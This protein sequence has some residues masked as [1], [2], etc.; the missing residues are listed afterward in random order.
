[1]RILSINIK[2]H[3]G[4]GTIYEE[5]VKKVLSDN[6]S[7]IE[8]ENIIPLRIGKRNVS[9]YLL[10]PLILWRLF[11]ISRRR[12]C[13]LTIRDFDS[14]LFLNQK[15]T[16]NIILFFHIDTSFLSFPFKIVYSFLQK[17]IFFN[18]KKADALVTISKYWQNYFQ[19]KGY[20]NI[21]LIYNAFNLGNYN[22][23]SKEVED[24]KKQHNLIGKPIIYIGDCQKAKGVKESYDTLKDL[25]VFL[26]TS[27]GDPR[28]KVP[29]KY[30]QLEHKDF[31]KLLK[32]SSIVITMSLFKEGWCRTAHE[33][34][35]LKT[36]VIGSGLGGMRELL[37]EGK[38]IICEDFDSLKAKVKYLL[39]HPE[40]RE[41]MGED[42]YNFAKNFT[43]ERFKNDWL[44]LIN[45]LI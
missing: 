5:M 9:K 37:E 14:S 36:P 25:D 23:T 41:K 17:L 43:L 3:S 38:Q 30:L 12:D 11:K 18:F 31:L 7:E 35:L 19:K 32:A 20:K 4:G 45:K 34:M 39:N 10:A 33:A 28:F 16:K 15:P 13:S 2:R 29:A 27:G 6:Y 21:F 24:F 26:V 44:D 40:I 1:M 42:G 8:F 22:F